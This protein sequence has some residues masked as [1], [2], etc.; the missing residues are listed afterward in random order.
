MTNVKILP[1]PKSAKYN[2][3]SLN[4]K[5]RLSKK[6]VLTLENNL[7]DFPKKIERLLAS[8]GVKVKFIEV[9]KFSEQEYKIE[10]GTKGIIVFGGGKS[11]LLFGFRSLVQILFQCDNK[12]PCGV[13][14][15]KPD[16]STRSFH[17][18][19]RTHKYKPAFIKE[20]FH[21]LAKFKYN[22]VVIEY[23]DTFPFEKEKFITGDIYYKKEQIA[24]IKKAAEDNNLELIPYQNA[25]GQLDYI[26]GLEPYSSLAEKSTVEHLRGRIIDVSNNKSQKFIASMLDELAA[27]HLTK[28]IFIGNSRISANDTNTNEKHAK[29]VGALAK[30]VAN[31]G[32]IPIVWADL[33]LKFPETVSDLPKK[34]IIVVRHESSQTELVKQLKFFNEAGY[35]VAS[36]AAIFKTPDNEFACDI[37]RAITNISEAAKNTKKSPANGLFI[38]SSVTVDAAPLIPLT[39]FPV[40][41]MAGARRM[42]IFT[43]LY[44]IA[45]AAEFAW[46][47][48]SPEEK[49]FS[50]LWTNTFFGSDDK[51]LSHIQLLLAKDYFVGATNAE[52]LRDRKKLL[53]IL[54]ELK[55]SIR[56]EQLAFLEFYARLAIH[57]VHVR[58]IFSHTPKKQEL[59]LLRTEIARL[60]A[61]HTAIM[62]ESLYSREI[63]DEQKYLF[64]HTETLLKRLTRK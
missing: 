8:T 34:T 13:I 36:S 22:T 38:Y 14:Q 26:L 12:I 62:K 27:S 35:S 9:D 18:D 30:H 15:D 56:K 39:G 10:I 61:K 41:L 45:A 60:K 1:E 32:K 57:A 23:Q 54:T 25:L 46:N 16:V 21:L 2:Q 7:K 42:H 51:K 20:I 58:Q 19:L 11:G 6:F 47:A 43:S 49:A 63:I 33:F 40:D 3:Q 5:K 28:K 37:E 44:A 29:F 4:I 17:L 31:K 52:I 59:S 53:K 64:G 55:P 48:S 24:E 50:E